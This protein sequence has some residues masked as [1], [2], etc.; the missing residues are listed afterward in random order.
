MRAFTLIA[1]VVSAVSIGV[2][3]AAPVPAP[4]TAPGPV[5]VLNGGGWGHGVGMSQWGAYGQAKVGRTFDQILSYYYTGTELGD[6]PEILQKRVRV[7]LADGVGSVTMTSRVPFSVLDGTGVRYPLPAGEL[8]IDSKLELPVDPQGELLKLVGPLQFR[9]GKGSPLKVRD[10]SYRGELRIT[11]AGK[12]L[13]LV[14]VVP[15]ESYLLGVVPGEM[16]KDW[17][18]EALKAQAVAARTYAAGNLLRGRPYDLYSDWRSQMYYGVEHEASGPTQAVRET[19]GKVVTYDGKIAQV[20][21]FS[22]SGGRTANAV[23]VYG[24]DVPYLRSVDDPWDEASPYHRW[25]PRQYR[26][27]ELAKAFKLSKPVVDVGYTPGTQGSPATITFT[28][29]DGTAS[30]FRTTDA[31]ARLGLRSST[32]RLGVLQ[33]AVPPASARAGAP[34]KLTGIVRDVEGAI[35]EKLGAG[36]IWTPAAQVRPRVDGTFVATLRPKATTTYRL[37]ATGVGGLA[38]VV[39]VSGSST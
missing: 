37:T 16:P 34:V 29:A 18:L 15:L 1:L 33:V 13:Q 9:P 4:V 22:S 10:M 36:G 7:L 20:F 2:A 5:F 25:E 30:S 26:G 8:T 24:S 28:T 14:N 12:R 11:A 39:K 19:K 3:R 23:D 35:I 27:G 17:P 38:I 6:A 21:Y 31:R 32:F